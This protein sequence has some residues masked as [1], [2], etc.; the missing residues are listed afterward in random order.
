[1]ARAKIDWVPATQGGRQSPPPGPRYITVARFQEAWNDWPRE[2]WSLIVEF[3]S[4][5]DDPLSTLAKVRFLAPN[6][7]EHLLHPGSL[8]ELYEGRQLVAK[9]QVVQD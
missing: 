6:G 1:M 3:E 9:A 8:F 2:A 4:G 7:P 5:S